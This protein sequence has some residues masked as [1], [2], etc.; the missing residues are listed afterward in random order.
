MILS[1]GWRNS[2]DHRHTFK[3]SIWSPLQALV[4]DQHS[5][6]QNIL[7]NHFGLQET[8][9]RTM[10]G[11][12]QWKFRKLYSSLKLVVKMKLNNS[13]TTWIN[14][15]NQFK[16]R[17]S[18]ETEDTRYQLVFDILIKRSFCQSQSQFCQI[19]RF[20]Q[21]YKFEEKEYKVSYFM[22]IKHPN[23]GSWMELV[24]SFH[25]CFN[26][27]KYSLITTIHFI[28]NDVEASQ[29]FQTNSCKKCGF[30]YWLTLKWVSKHSM[31]SN[32]PVHSDDHD[33]I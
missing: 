14:I 21:G 10:N 20:A 29:S 19:L 1:I 23:Q 32:T 33:N 17:K 25:I 31:E 15:P 4:S 16:K 18:C 2:N 3:G 11:S 6:N 28:I 22:T 24:R 27:N 8:F 5:K 12:S 9:R 13:F 7:E 26:L 30:H